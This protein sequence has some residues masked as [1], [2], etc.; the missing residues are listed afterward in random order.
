VTDQPD[1]S[2]S[3]LDFS[4]FARLGSQLARVADAMEDSERR[5]AKLFQSLHQVPVGPLQVPITAG[6]GVLQLTEMSGPKAGFMWSIRRLTASG[7]TAGSVIAYRN[8]AVIGGAIAAGSEPLI[9]FTV[10]GTNFIGRG[11]ALLDQN[12]ALIIVCTGITLASGF[13]WVQ[14][15][16]AADN[17]NRELLPDYLGI[18][19]R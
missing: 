17:F 3:G 14:I 4:V 9:P 7:Y 13:S 15:N 2:G 6:A 11:E 10:A 1:G 12:D 16:G 8:G 18:G 5:K 19:D